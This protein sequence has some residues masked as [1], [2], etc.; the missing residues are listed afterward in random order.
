VALRLLPETADRYARS[1]A[2]EDCAEAEPQ[3]LGQQETCHQYERNF[4]EVRK[5][6]TIPTKLLPPLEQ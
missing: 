1:E 4:R 5:I 3:R 6:A 2:T